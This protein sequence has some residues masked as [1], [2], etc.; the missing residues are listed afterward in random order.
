MSAFDP[1]RTSPRRHFAGL[2][3]KNYKVAPRD[4]A[5]PVAP[6]WIGAGD[7]EVFGFGAEGRS[8]EA[9][10]RKAEPQ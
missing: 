2:Q 10:S 7:T 1:K 4:G 5:L 8:S 3:L 9:F 6:V